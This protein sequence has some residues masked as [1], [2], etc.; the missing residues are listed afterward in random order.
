M[1]ST[2]GLELARK[3]G[4][5][6]LVIHGDSMMVVM[7]ERNLLKNR[8]RPVTKTHHILK[9]MVDVYKVINLLHLVRENNQ[10]ANIRAN[11]G[12]DL[13]CGILVCDQKVFMRNWIP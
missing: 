12:V 6:E 11:K 9:C 1:G 5:E 8:K 13:E 10:Q 4:I 7:E 3:L 2:K